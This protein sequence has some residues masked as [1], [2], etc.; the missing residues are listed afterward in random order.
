MSDDQEKGFE[1]PGIYMNLIGYPIYFT[2]SLSLRVYFR[3]YKIDKA[4]SFTLL[5]YELKLLILFSNSILMAVD[6]FYRDH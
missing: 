2:L 1:V 5:F 4:A 3:K 6:Y